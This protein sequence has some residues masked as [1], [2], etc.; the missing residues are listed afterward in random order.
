MGQEYTDSVRSKWLNCVKLRLVKLVVSDHCPSSFPQ[1]NSVTLKELLAFISSVLSYT[2]ILN[3]SSR[4][5]GFVAIPRSQKNKI[6][7]LEFLVDYPSGPFG[8]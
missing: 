2:H 4:V 6:L 5:P 7:T 3:K 8:N 1:E